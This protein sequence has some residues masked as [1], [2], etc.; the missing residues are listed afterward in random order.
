MK[1]LR[2][3]CVGAAGT[4]DMC[5]RGRKGGACG[6]DRDRAWLAGVTGATVVCC[7]LET[8]YRFACC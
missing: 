2:L 7:G 3:P 1:G 4:R 6:R 5:S 8:A